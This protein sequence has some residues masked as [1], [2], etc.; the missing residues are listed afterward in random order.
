MRYRS[1]TQL[2][3]A[4]P[5]SC[6]TDQSLFFP[7]RHERLHGTCREPHGFHAVSFRRPPYRQSHHAGRHFLFRR[8]MGKQPHRAPANLP[9]QGYVPSGPAEGQSRIRR[10]KSQREAQRRMPTA[11][12]SAAADGHQPGERHN[13]D[14]PSVPVRPDGQK[15]V[16]DGNKDQQRQNIKSPG[17]ARMIQFLGHASS[18]LGAASSVVTPANARIRARS[19]SAHG[20]VARTSA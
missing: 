2:T 9:R 20:R 8:Q 17:H 12:E 4:P 1:F 16:E 10:Q 13:R 5:C 15:A 3:N 19:S 14:R 11:P 6:K 7:L 18:S